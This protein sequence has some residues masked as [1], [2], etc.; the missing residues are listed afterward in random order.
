ME[1]GKALKKIVFRFIQYLIDL[2]EKKKVSSLSFSIWGVTANGSQHM[3]IG[4][5]DCVELAA[6]H[7]TPLFVADK[8]LLENNYREFYES[9]KAHSIEFEIHYSYKTNPVP[10]ILR[11]L[12]DCG[13]G[14]EVISP[15][16][17]WLALKLGVNPGSIV[18]NGP[19]KSDEGLRLAIENGVKL[20]NINSLR[21]IEKIEQIAADSGKKAQ[22]G[23]RI[24]TGVGWG[25][26]FGLKLQSGEALHAFEIITKSRQLEAL[27]IHFHLGTNLDNA[28]MYQMAL[29]SAMELVLNIKKKFGIKIKY[30]D[31]GGGYGVP[32]VRGLGK[33]EIKLNTFVYKPYT[34]PNPANMPCITSFADTIV[35]ALKNECIKHK[36]DPPVLLFEPGRALTSN[37]EIMLTRVGDQKK[38]SNGFKIALLDAGVNTAYPLTWEYHEIFLAN[39]MSASAN[40]RY[41]LAGPICTP[42][43]FFIKSK[44][45]PPLH[46]GDLLAIMDAGAYFTSFSNNF[47]FPRPPIIMTSQG[48]HWLVRG[49]ETYEN[50]VERDV[51]GF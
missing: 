41:G 13:A 23:V 11:V 39:N 8:K 46:V 48:H 5:C 9:L 36:I 34:P 6:E 32:T 30:I 10:G 18:Y 1:I 40:E 25:S 12:H 28:A 43:D 50:L 44:R 20:I 24:S 45:L 51:L 14:A 15:Y 27:A 3:L 38:T 35:K 16:E 37:A 22:V 33:K 7:G 21:E 19:N 17:L 29:K 2:G 4:G 49:K 42:M 47:S 26:Q 31:L